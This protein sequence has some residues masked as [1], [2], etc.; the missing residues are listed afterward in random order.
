[1]Q[2]DWRLDNSANNCYRG[3]RDAK[4]YRYFICHA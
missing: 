1:M 2:S 4:W 3:A